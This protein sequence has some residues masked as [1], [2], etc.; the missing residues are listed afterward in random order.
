MNCETRRKA[1][2]LNIHTLAQEAGVVSSSVS[3]LEAGGNY[4]LSTRRKILE[5][6]KRLEAE[7][8]E[9]GYIGGPRKTNICQS[10]RRPDIARARKTLGMTQSA[11]AEQWKTTKYEISKIESGYDTPDLVLEEMI[12]GQLRAMMNERGLAWP[13][14][15]G[16]TWKTAQECVGRGENPARRTGDVPTTLKFKSV[17]QIEQDHKAYMDYHKPTCPRCDRGILWGPDGKPY[18]C[19]ICG[20]K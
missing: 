12:D 4:L 17:E 8:K 3:R 5:A 19:P 11:L 7:H 15:S 20:G 10:R 13:D 14:L 1:I 9:I 16:N 2:G 18:V 6:L